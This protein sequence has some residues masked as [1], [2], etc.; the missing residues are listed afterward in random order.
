MANNDMENIAKMVVE[1]TNGKEVRGAIAKG[2]RLYDEV[3]GEVFER[4]S[5]VESDNEKLRQ[6]I[7]DL[8]TENKELNSKIDKLNSKIDK[9]NSDKVGNTDFDAKLSE[10]NEDWKDRLRRVTLGTDS[11]TLNEVID[12]ILKAKGVI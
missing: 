6:R 12:K 11:E 3:T 7:L 4:V 9:L 10:F 2:F 8:E 5:D 1:S